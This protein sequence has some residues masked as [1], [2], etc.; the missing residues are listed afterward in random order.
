MNNL[1]F[2][3]TNSGSFNEKILNNV[4]EKIKNKFNSVIE[5]YDYTSDKTETENVDKLII[6]KSQY[7]NHAREVSTTYPLQHVHIIFIMG[8]DGMMHEVV[9]G[10]YRNN[11]FNN[12]II[13]STIPSGSGNHLSKALHIHSINGWGESLHKMELTRVFP[14]IVH[15]SDDKKILSINTIIGGLPRSINDTASY[16]AHYIPHFIGWL[17]Y[18][19]S[20]LF[21]IFL[22]TENNITL[23][24]NCDATDNNE[25]SIHNI[26]A[27][28]IQ[29][30]QTCGS[31]L[32]ISRNI[33]LDQQNISLSYF[34]DYSKIRILYEFV[35]EKLGYESQYLIRS[36]NEHGIIRLKGTSSVSIDGQN[37]H[38]PID[39]GIKINRS[40]E[41]FNFII[42]K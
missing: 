1:L 4:I 12:K 10:L 24:C 9:N 29:T 33:S 36:I 16:I 13:L 32:M 28:F 26:I 17:K 37:E 18:D 22:K 34:T 40:S 23:Y 20:T 6:I 19:L 14:T 11:T 2:V 25:S 38:I 41:Y 15:T 3:N 27:I 7:A 5:Y 31:D 39:C 35:K 30:T 42:L 21:N 8:G